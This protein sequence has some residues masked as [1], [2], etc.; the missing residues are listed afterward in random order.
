[1]D[2]GNE[3]WVFLSHSNKDY[4]K[5]RQVRNLLEEQKFRPLM[6]FLCCLDDDQEIDNLI[7]REI[8]RRTRFIYCES[9]NSKASRWVQEEVMYIK[10]KDRIFETIDLDLSITEIKKQLDNFRKK[11]NIFIS[12]QTEDTELAR[13]IYNRIKKYEFN[14]W[15]DFEN[16][17]A[18]SIFS[19]QIT[20]AL[21]NAVNN[22]YVITLL[23]SNIF[24]DYSS[25]RR[26]LILS[27]QKGCHPEQ[28]IIPVVQNKSILEQLGADSE[29]GILKN[30]HPIDSSETELEERSDFIV[31]AI[32]QRLLPPGAVLSH[33]MNFR[34]GING[35]KDNDEAEKLFRLYYKMAQEGLEKSPT[36]NIGMSLCYEYGYGVDINYDKALEYLNDAIREGLSGFGHIIER[37]KKKSE[38]KCKA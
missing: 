25:I 34:D 18:G 20:N 28:N 8:D 21:L 23:N 6:F 36:A 19:E 32:I 7:K 31:D 13:T 17:Q 12:Y 29:I 2:K 30:F 3:I 24:N 33:A 35:N 4:E 1:M 26:E 15:I 27:L 16:I 5:V 37:V 38:G 22:G 10:S 14:V 11:A 9:E